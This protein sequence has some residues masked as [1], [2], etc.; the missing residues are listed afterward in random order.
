[1]QTTKTKALDQIEQFLNQDLLYSNSNWEIYRE[2]FLNG[3]R[4]DFVCLNPSKGILIIRYLNFSQ[5]NYDIEK[6]KFI[7]IK[8]NEIVNIQNPISYLERL[9]NSIKELYLPRLGEK[10]FAF[11]AITSCVIFNEDREKSIDLL[12]HFS[13]FNKFID[14]KNQFTLGCLNSLQLTDIFP[15]YKHDLSK[16]MTEELAMD[17]RNW[18]YKPDFE[19]DQQTTISLP[20]RQWDLIHTPPKSKFRRIKGS[21]GSG[22]SFVLC[23]RAVELAKESKKVLIVTYNITLINYLRELCD[24]FHSNAQNYIEFIHFHEWMSKTFA[25][26]GI[27][28]KYPKFEDQEE[29]TKNYLEKELPNQL[30]QALEKTSFVEKYDAILVDEGQDFNRQWW[31][32]LQQS[33]TENGEML[34]VADTAQDIYI[35]QLN[36]WIDDPMKNLGMANRWTEL[37]DSFRIPNNVKPLLNKFQ[38]EFFESKNINL[39]VSKQDDLMHC[40]VKWIDADIDSSIQQCMEELIILVKEDQNQKRSFTDLTFL[41]DNQ[42]VGLNVVEKLRAAD[43]SLKVAD[44]FKRNEKDRNQKIRKIAFTKLNATVKATTIHSFKG[45]ESRMIVILITRAKTPKDLSVIYTGLTRIKQHPLGS[46]LTIINTTERLKN[47]QEK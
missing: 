16:L 15:N 31:N 24:R 38:N 43:K 9:Q 44:T 5:G 33:L 10:A 6:D 27:P 1:M 39:I 28:I 19:E 12:S 47:Y 21:A 22:K 14:K 8:T 42:S 46:F 40:Q 32:T 4:P 25:F 45:W 26:L 17:F 35:R 20:K 30:I 23:G 11:R 7:D 36:S 29:K 41:T 34:L 3:D 2:P 37:N 18:L 13:N